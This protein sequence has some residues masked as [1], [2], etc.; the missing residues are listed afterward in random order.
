MN[1]KSQIQ[2]WLLEKPKDAFLN[3]ALAMEYIAEG[4]DDEAE[5][6]LNELIQKEP[7][8]HASYYH[9]GALY[10]RN[11]ELK[12]AENVYEIGMKVCKS[13]GETHAYN[14]LHAVYEELI[15]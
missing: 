14:E 2:E 3:Y 7:E 5:S 12:R 9:L 4:N 6:I 1:R 15:Y 11:N 10:E 13:L 8:Y